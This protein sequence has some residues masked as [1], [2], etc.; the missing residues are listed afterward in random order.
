LIRSYRNFFSFVAIGNAFM[1]KCKSDDTP[2]R[3]TIST[4][5]YATYYFLFKD[6]RMEQNDFFSANPDV[7][8][9]REIW[10]LLENKY[11]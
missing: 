7:N 4:G 2:F 8:M 9:A 1:S 10:N 3:K 6:Q 11:I 5:V